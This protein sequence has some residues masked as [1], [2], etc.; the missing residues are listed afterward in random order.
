MSQMVTY[1]PSLE[2]HICLSIQPL[3]SHHWPGDSTMTW[4]MYMVNFYSCDKWARWS[5]TQYTVYTFLYE[6]VKLFDRYVFLSHNLALCELVDLKFGILQFC[7]RQRH[8]IM[9][10]EATGMVKQATRVSNY[11]HVWNVLL[12]ISDLLGHYSLDCHSFRGSTAATVGW[13]FH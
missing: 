11:V 8:K 7:R 12:N 10:I 2:H 3:L 6:T 9:W 13:G 1:L 5:G 4:H